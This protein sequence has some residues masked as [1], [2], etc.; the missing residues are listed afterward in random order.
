MA[1]RAAGAPGLAIKTYVYLH[2]NFGSSVP[3]ELRG[4]GN[5]GISILKDMTRFAPEFGTLVAAPFAEGGAA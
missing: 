5:Y 3:G 4:I 2:N 1:T